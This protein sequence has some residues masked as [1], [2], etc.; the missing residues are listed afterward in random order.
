MTR[1]HDP[2]DRHDALPPVPLP[3][4][5]PRRDDGAADIVVDFSDLTFAQPYPTHD[6]PAPGTGSYDNGYDLAGGFTSKG[7]FFN[8][9]YGYN[10]TFNYDYWSG[11]SY[12][13]VSDPTKSLSSIGSD[14]LHEYAA[15]P[16]SAPGGS[17]IYGVSYGSGAY[18]NLPAGTSPV[19]FEV[20]NTTY[21]YL[22]MVEGDGFAKQFGKNDYFELKIFGYSGAGGTGT[23]RGEVDFF[24]ANY[25]SDSSLPVAVWALVDLSSLA[26][27][28][29]LSFDYASSDVGMFGINTPLSFAMD[30][31]ILSTAAVPEPS[32]L[33]L[34]DRGAGWAGRRGHRPSHGETT[35]GRRLTRVQ[36]LPAKPGSGVGFGSP[37]RRRYPTSP[38]S[39]SWRSRRPEGQTTSTRSTFVADPSPKWS[40]GSPAER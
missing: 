39:P 10:A 13:N 1:T 15:I 8:N 32:S 2:G 17:G 35:P 26:G 19:S 6:A 29:S 12:S 27:S 9:S 38:A 36:P 33:A 34:I 25:T 11:W 14:Y 18:I 4:P 7:A 23:K 22:S 30:D 24:L 5:D 28:G 31:L 20:T 40:R 16:G 3:R 37:S 21:D